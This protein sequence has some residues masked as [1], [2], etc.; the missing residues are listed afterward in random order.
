MVDSG[1]WCD[2]GFTW[3]RVIRRNDIGPGGVCGSWCD[4]NMPQTGTGGFTSAFQDGRA[5][6]IADDQAVLV[7]VCSTIGITKLAKTEEV[8][9]EAWDDMSLAHC[10]VG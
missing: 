10:A 7:K 3:G 1:Q 9:G 4:I 2:G 6:G 8:V 5:C